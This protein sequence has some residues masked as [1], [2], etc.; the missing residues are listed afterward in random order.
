MKSLITRIVATIAAVLFSYALGG[1]C[2]SLLWD[3]LYGIGQSVISDEWYYNGKAPIVFWGQA[4]GAAFGFI[5]AVAS[6]QF[7]FT[8]IA[9]Q[10]GIGFAAGL[11]IAIGGWKASLVA[12]YVTQLTTLIASIVLVN[13]QRIPIHISITKTA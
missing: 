9:A 8:S 1:I 2:T 7:I 6:K 13:L 11:I 5:R 3:F 10:H 12:Y 4:C